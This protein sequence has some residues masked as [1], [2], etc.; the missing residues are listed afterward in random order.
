MFVFAIDVDELA[1]RLAQS[2]ALLLSTII[3]DAKSPRKSYLTLMDRYR[4]CIYKSMCMIMCLNLAEYEYEWVQREAIWRYMASALGL[5]H[6][7][8]L[9]LAC[10][11]IEF[12]RKKLNMGYYDVKQHLKDHCARP[13]FDVYSTE[14]RHGKTDKGITCQIYEAA[15][16][17]DKKVTYA[18]CLKRVKKYVLS[19]FVVRSLKGLTYLFGFLS[20]FAF[21]FSSLHSLECKKHFLCVCPNVCEF[22]RRQCSALSKCCNRSAHA[23]AY[24]ATPSNVR[25]N[26][27]DGQANTHTI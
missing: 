22:L 2:L 13:A 7:V 24:V 3:F 15:S 19:S 16:R 11:S 4:L 17:T 26:S 27:H 9:G 10:H 23:Q 12:E 20:F 14:H 18:S 6:I 25:D 5:L 8:F 1:D 21:A